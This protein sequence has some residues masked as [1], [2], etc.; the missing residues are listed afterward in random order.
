MP[1]PK[2]YFHVSQELN[3]DPELWEFTT[4]FGDRSIRTWMQILVYLDRSANQWRTSG[5]WLATLSRTVRQSVAN[6]SRQIRWLSEKGWLAVRETA[7]DGSPAVF[8]APKWAEYNRRQEHKRSQSVPDSG[9]LK[10]R[11]D[12]PSFP[13][14]TPSLSF[15]T[16]KSKK[17]ER[18][19]SSVSVVPT[20]SAPKTE[21]TWR[22]Y[23]DAYRSR[24]GADPIRNASVNGILSRLVDRLGADVAP[25]VAAFYVQHNNPFYVGKRHPVNLLL[26]DCEGLHTQWVTGVK[27][28]TGEARNV[29]RRDDAQAQ[30]A[31][32][33]AMMGEA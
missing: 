22:T 9:T 11:I 10:A 15:P 6:V 1:V 28:T 18:I 29:E 4:E 27:A 21:S 17:E 5:D 23:S 33:K 31:R 24:Y 12:A 13:T 30:I 26:A 8:E 7:E 25:Q 32:V 2:R 16:P 14:P 20:K 19:K 3:H